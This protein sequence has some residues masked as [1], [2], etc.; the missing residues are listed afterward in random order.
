MLVAVATHAVRLGDGHVGQL[1]VDAAHRGRGLVLALLHEVFR[2]DTAAGRP[3]T[4][5]GVDG[6]NDGARR[7]YDRAGM[8]VVQE[9]HRWERDV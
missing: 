8:H 3:R 6:E 7:L 5:L 9:F 4:T 2:R 1:A